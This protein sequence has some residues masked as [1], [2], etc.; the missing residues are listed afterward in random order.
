MEFQTLVEKRRSLRSYVA[1]TTI[2]KEELLTIIKCAQEAPSWKNSETG[3]YYVVCSPEKMKDISARALPEFN[4]NS[5]NNAAALIVT[6]FEANR[7]GFE[8]DGSAVNEIGNEW[9]AYDLGLQNMLLCLKAKEL[10]Y[11]T[12]IM[13]IRDAEVL[14]KELSIPESQHVAAVIAVGKGAVEMSRPVRKDIKDIACFF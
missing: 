8:R 6:T 2:S 5:S 4:Q 12:L 9:G 13:G 11:D 10:G 7:A 3:R 14:R 1:N